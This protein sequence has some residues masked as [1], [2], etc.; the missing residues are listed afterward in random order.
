MTE[1][2]TQKLFSIFVNSII[3]KCA[4]ELGVTSDFLK[5]AYVEKDDVRADINN[6]ISRHIEDLQ[7]A[8]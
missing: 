4:S 5:K 8:A 7:A 6:I 2:D 1:Q 3:E